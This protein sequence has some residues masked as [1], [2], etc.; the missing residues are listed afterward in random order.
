M[1][2]WSG[3]AIPHI[4]NQIKQIN[5]FIEKI[6]HTSDYLQHR[7]YLQQFIDSKINERNYCEEQE[8]FDEYLG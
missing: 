7:K 4:N 1:S 3:S 2:S 8:I 5:R 6:P